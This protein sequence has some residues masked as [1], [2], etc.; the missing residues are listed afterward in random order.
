MDEKISVILLLFIFFWEGGH[1]L[2]AQG[3]QIFKYEPVYIYLL[4]SNY[5]KFLN[6][7]TILDQYF[8]RLSYFY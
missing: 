3:C 6:C 4:D 7:L 8:F 2:Y 1:K 5:C